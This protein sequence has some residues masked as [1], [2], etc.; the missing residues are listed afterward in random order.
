MGTFDS[1]CSDKINWFEG[2]MG[3]MKSSVTFQND[4]CKEYYKS[5]MVHP[6]LMVPP[7]KVCMMVMEQGQICCGFLCSFVHSHFDA[8]I[9]YPRGS[10]AFL[11]R[12]IPE[13]LLQ[14]GAPQLFRPHSPPS[15]LHAHTRPLFHTRTPNIYPSSHSTPPFS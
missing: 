8:I 9:L 1:S 13:G 11:S 7:T 3:W 5:V 2:M 15:R 4:P 10:P 14:S 6:A 12:G